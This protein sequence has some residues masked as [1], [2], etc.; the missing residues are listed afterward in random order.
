MKNR[1]DM[2]AVIKGLN[3]DHGLLA[4]FLEAAD[5]IDWRALNRRTG[6]A[7]TPKPVNVEA[8]EA[9]TVPVLPQVEPPRPSPAPFVFR[10][11]NLVR[12]S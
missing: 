12:A 10:R 1:D 11:A 9:A 8:H 7:V 5:K 3:K 2:G 6:I 4:A